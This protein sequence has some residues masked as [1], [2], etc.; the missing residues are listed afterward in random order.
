[1]SKPLVGAVIIGVVLV[2]FYFLSPFV[3]LRSLGVAAKAADADA[4]SLDVDFPSVR[5]SLKGQ[6]DAF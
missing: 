4:L 2:A 5:E 3:F 6:F 1:M